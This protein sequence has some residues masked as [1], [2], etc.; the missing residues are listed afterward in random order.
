MIASS[1][2]LVNLVCAL[3]VCAFL[4]VCV[5]LCVCM[6]FV[7]QTRN[8]YICCFSVGAVTLLPLIECI[9][10]MV[11]APVCIL[12]RVMSRIGDCIC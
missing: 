8:S 12:F 7:E 6:V 9:E 5:C 10:V 1:S 2:L 4:C 11:L 3:L